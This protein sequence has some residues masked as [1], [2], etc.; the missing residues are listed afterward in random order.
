MAIAWGG[1]AMRDAYYG[2]RVGIE[3][4]RSGRQIHVKYYVETNGSVYY[5]G[6][7]LNRSGNVSGGVGFNWNSGGGQMLVNEADFTGSANS[8]CTFGASVSL[9][10]WGGSCSVSVSVSIPMNKPAAVT[11]VSASRVSDA[12]ANVSWT[13]HA[14]SGAPYSSIY[15]DRQ[16]RRAD[17]SF[18]AWQNVA[19]VSGSASSY[20]DKSIKANNRYWWRVTAENGAGQSSRSSSGG[21]STTPAPPTNVVAEKNADG[22][23]TVSWV[24]AAPYGGTGFLVFDGGVQV[25]S[26]AAGVL[27]WTDP[28]PSTEVPHTYTLRM[29]ETGSLTSAD[30]APSN[31][32]QLLA[33]PNAPGGLAPNG[34][35]VAAGE[36]LT[37]SWVHN[38]VDSSAQTSAQVRVWVESMQQWVTLS[39]TGSAQKMTVD[40]PSVIGVEV[41]G[42]TQWQVRTRGAYMPESADGWSQWSPVATVTVMDRP[43]VVVTSPED[44]DQVNVPTPTIHWSYYQAEGG[45]QASWQVQVLDAGGL[46]VGEVS[47]SGT[48]MV[49]ACPVRLADQQAYTVR[50]RVRS[51]HGLWSEWAQAGVQVAYAAPLAPDVQV[52]WD[53]DLGVAVLQITNLDPTPLRGLA[54]AQGVDGS[55]TLANA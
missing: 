13:R 7:T 22:S 20:S 27:S 24:N 50:A 39:I 4:S 51:S 36:T 17:G 37:L 45:A 34:V 18:S 38:P 16:Q 14:T 9:P 10:W 41:G 47:G 40:D 1:W 12:Q 35:T 32:V 8:T 5:N 46:V 43:T 25:A 3:T 49:A 52:S 53:G 48:G 26:V 55:L 44:G 15:V 21:V 54:V 42:S 23:I 2:Q 28:S 33:P 6:L 29:T 30:S 31:T 19:K 11:G